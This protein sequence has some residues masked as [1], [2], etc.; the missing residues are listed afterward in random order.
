MKHYKFTGAWRGMTLGQIRELL[1]W[2][3]EGVA[4]DAELPAELAGVME[5]TKQHGVAMYQTALA[6][7]HSVW[8]YVAENN[9]HVCD[10]CG[11]VRATDPGSPD[12]DF[13]CEVI[14]SKGAD[15]A[16][17]IHDVKYSEPP[18]SHAFAVYNTRSNRWTCQCGS[19]RVGDVGAWLNPDT[20][21]RH[22]DYREDRRDMV[23]RCNDCPAI[24]SMHALK[25][26]SY[27]W[28]TP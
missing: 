22:V 20:T 25:S 24:A 21:C 18:C 4:S 26:D 5:E 10:G 14:A 27:Q 17:A 16:I 8:H 12:G 9:V 7:P 1:G 28:R 19:V 13:G 6:C 15:G 2:L 11:V 23:L 3:R